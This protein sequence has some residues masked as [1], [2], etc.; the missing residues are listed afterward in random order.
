VR[1][2][3]T[4]TLL[5]RTT[6]TATGSTV[7]DYDLTPGGA[8]RSVLGGRA[9]PQYVTQF[10]DELPERTELSRRFHEA[11]GFEDSAGRPTRR[12][13]E[14][15][16]IRQHYQENLHGANWITVTEAEER[17]VVRRMFAAQRADAVAATAETT[18]PGEMNSA[19]Y[20]A[21]E[22][23]RAAMRGIPGA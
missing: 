22:K 5:P 10:E 2:T 9:E 3:R 17:E 11:W 20:A 6:R 15:R 12:A 18:G 19:D 13:E 8:F 23:R 1:A 4:A 14:R 16:L 7:T 21:M